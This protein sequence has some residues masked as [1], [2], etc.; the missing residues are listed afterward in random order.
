MKTGKEN[1]L[2]SVPSKKFYTEQMLALLR[3]DLSSK[4]FYTEQMLALLRT[5]RMQLRNHVDT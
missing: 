3:T 2:S 5:D 4:K 1:M